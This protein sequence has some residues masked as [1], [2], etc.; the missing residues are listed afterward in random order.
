MDLDD[1]V[2]VDIGGSEKNCGADAAQVR[3][4]GAG[5]QAPKRKVV[6]T[7]IRLTHGSPVGGTGE[8]VSKVLYDLL[9]MR[10]RSQ[11]NQAPKAPRHCRRPPEDT[12]GIKPDVFVPYYAHYEYN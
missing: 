11:G 12:A 7:S 2:T 10:I 1:A 6:M 8:A 3:N 5:G 9:E 4:I